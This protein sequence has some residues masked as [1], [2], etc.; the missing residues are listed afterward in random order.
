LLTAY[1]WSK[2][3]SGPSDIGGQVG[4]GLYI[5]TPQDVFN[6]TQDRSISGF[7][8]TQRFVQT[9][10]YDIP[11][12]KKMRGPGRYALDGWEVS[13]IIT[14]QSGFPAVVTD[15]IDTTGIGISARPDQI[16]AGNLDSGQRT[17]QKWFN[18]AA[19]VQAPYGRF[20]NAPRTGDIRLPGIFNIDFSATKAFHIGETRA[21]QMRMELFNVMNH[22]NPDPA[23]IDLA[24]N[25]ATF[26]TIGG[27]V[28]GYTTRV[29]QLGAKLNF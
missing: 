2:S 12:F 7:D 23:T 19:F 26:G 15:N 4:G 16:A 11:F 21:L 27:G 13:T 10:L 6:G 17:W 20:G 28:H 24:V 1:T 5:G 18:S 14:A 22:F 25:S 9:L 8:E 3:M 29:I